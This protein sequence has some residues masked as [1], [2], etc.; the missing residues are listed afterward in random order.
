MLFGCA[1]AAW[2]QHVAYCNVTA[3]KSERLGNGV[4]LT[5]EADGFMTVSAR[6]EIYFDLDQ[7]QNGHWDKAG[8]ALS[9]LP[10][11]ITNARSQVGSITDV[12]IYP[13]SHV[14]LSVPPEAREGV[15]LD[16]KVVLFTSAVVVALPGYEL[17]LSANNRP[18]ARF[19]LAQDRRSLMILITSDRRTTVPAERRTPSANAPRSLSVSESHGLLAI[20]AE[21]AD[22]R[23][24]AR[25]LSLKSGRTVVADDGL[26]RTVSLSLPDLP[27]RQAVEAIAAAYGLSVE[28]SGAVIRLTDGEVTGTSTATE[29]AFDTIRLQHIP[30]VA[31]RDAL[32]EFLLR[33]IHVNTLDNSL[34]VSGPKSL[35][36]KLRDDIRKL[37]TPVPQIEIEAQAVEFASSDDLETLLSAT[38]RW[39][40]DQLS[41]DTETGDVQYIFAGPLPG[42]F[43]AALRAEVTRGNAV[44]RARP[45]ATV[46]NGETAHLFVGQEKLVQVTYLDY[47]S[48]LYTG[49]I[50]Q[51]ELGVKLDVTPWTGGGGLITAQVSPEVS[52]IAET[53]RGTGEPTVAIRRARTTVRVRDGDTLVIGGLSLDQTGR[54]RI[55]L[56]PLGGILQGR[57][58]STGRSELVWFVTARVSK[59]EAK[60]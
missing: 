11:S 53:A 22:L 25:R 6:P 50:L 3:I 39:H 13:V 60:R 31:A 52:N 18:S 43:D 59:S 32:P 45:K 2:P 9:E 35:I 16:L 47:F 27:L 55:G 51:V 44:I 12:G 24:L 23:E 37:D 15:G 4:M 5:I 10:F 54:T 56:P 41:L 21:N 46:L 30:A 20:D 34:S 1:G 49:K 57:R 29:M 33:Y 38:A 58:N 48:G 17:P 26:V 19:Q 8:K 28:D 14:G 36:A 40:R 7:I 42:S